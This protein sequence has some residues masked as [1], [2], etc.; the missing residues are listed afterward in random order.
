MDAISTPKPI[1][2]SI[3]ENKNFLRSHLVISAVV[4]A[5][6]AAL[7]AAYVVAYA[8]PIAINPA[9]VV[10]LCGVIGCCSVI[11]CLFYVAHARRVASESRYVDTP[12]SPCW[13]ATDQET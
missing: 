11:S 7:S 1:E 5:I 10:S 4:N 3:D 9:L 8:I 12:R 2:I 6:M 13:S